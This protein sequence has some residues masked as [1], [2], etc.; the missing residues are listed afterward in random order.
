MNIEGGKDNMYYFI[1]IKGAGMSALAVI[2]KQLGN[3]V[4]GSD[5]D[6]HFFT[7]SELKKNNIPFYVYCEDN[8][9]EGMIIIKGA[10]I[11]DDNIELKRAY[12][13]GLKGIAITDHETVNAH[14]KAIKYVEKM[15]AKDEN[16]K[17]FKLI[18]GNEI[19][20][21]RNGLNS[22]NY[23]SKKDKFYHFIL[24]AVDEIGHQQIRELSTRAYEHSFMKSR[25]RRVPTYYS[26]VEEIIGSN[27]GHVIA[28]SACLGGFLGT[29]LL[30]ASAREKYQDY[31]LGEI[32]MLKNWIEYIQSIFGKDNFFLELQ[33]SDTDEQVYVNNWLITF[34]REYNIPAIVTTD[35]HYQTKEDREFHKAYL[36]SKEG[37]REVDAFY[38]TTYL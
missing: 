25:M 22:E 4:S 10:S 23:D 27:P 18:L 8:I 32:D 13:L 28:S 37:D 15:R 16:W 29:K 24:L 5:I 9:K 19:Y 14:I 26:D 2:L 3:V 21:C 36:N 11:K 35:S 1:G 31:F 38:S 6:K 34:S 33:P 17:N 12:E 7:E 20:L 30:A